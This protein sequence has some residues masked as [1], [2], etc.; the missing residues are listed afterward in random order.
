MTTLIRSHQKTHIFSFALVRQATQVVALL[1]MGT[2]VGVSYS[3]FMQWPGKLTLDQATYLVVQNNLIQYFVGMGFVEIPLLVILAVVA[4]LV[5]KQRIVLAFTLTALGCCLLAFG[6]WGF[7]IEPIN[8]QI[9]GKTLAELPVN[10]AELRNQW[11]VYHFKR[12]ILYALG[13]IALSCSV[14][15]R[16]GSRV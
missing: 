11:H 15:E 2:E 5:R 6:I 4:W 16:K 7:L 14:L 3:H 13:M 10:W 9:D 12:L 8:Q 1:L